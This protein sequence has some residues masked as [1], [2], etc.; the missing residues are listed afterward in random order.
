MTLE[1]FEDVAGLSPQAIAV[2]QDVLADIRACTDCHW[3]L[4]SILEKRYA[5]SGPEI[6]AIV[7]YMRVQGIGRRIGSSSKGYYWIETN[8]Q[9]DQT[10]KQL[11]GRIFRLKRVADSIRQLDLSKDDDSQISLL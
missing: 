7:S 8:E 11:D 9:R 5:V 4:S 6:R 10:L 2:S 3:I 1:G